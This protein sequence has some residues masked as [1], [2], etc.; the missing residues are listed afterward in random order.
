VEL[1]RMYNDGQNHS[2]GGNAIDD[3][4]TRQHGDGAAI[5]APHAEPAVAPAFAPT[6]PPTLVAPPAPPTLVKTEQSPWPEW[7]TVSVE[8]D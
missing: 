7:K 1:I 5:L 4:V 2:K 8:I 3:E 6:A